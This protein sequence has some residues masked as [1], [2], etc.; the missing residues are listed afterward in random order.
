MEQISNVIRTTLAPLMQ[1]ERLRHPYA[2]WARIA[3][4]LSIPFIVWSHDWLLICLLVVAIFSHPFWFPP[5]VQAGDETP[6]MTR[7]IDRWQEWLEKTPTKDKLVHFF[8]GIVLLMPLLWF[9]W[10]NSLFWSAYFV[11][12]AIAYKTMFC[13]WIMQDEKKE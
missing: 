10:A 12:A 4:G 7:L 6:F 1:W 9:L 11:L 13:W 2:S 3:L 5:Y 8:P